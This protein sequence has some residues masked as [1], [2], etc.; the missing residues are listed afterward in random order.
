L[1]TG[2]GSLAILAWLPDA[3]VDTVLDVLAPVFKKRYPRISRDMLKTEIALGRQRGYVVLLDVVID[4][5]GGIA[6]P[7]LGGDGKP[8]GALSIAALTQRIATRVAT[9]GPALKKAANELSAHY[10]Q[11]EAA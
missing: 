7:I 9:L 1:N 4:Q 2:A 8:V 10:A 11:R 6:A 3:E 5:M